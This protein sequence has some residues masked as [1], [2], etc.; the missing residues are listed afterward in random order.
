MSQVEGSRLVA[1]LGITL[2]GRGAQTWDHRAKTIGMVGFQNFSGGGGGE[3][4]DLPKNGKN[5]R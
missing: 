3:E 1:L 4:M 5:T 2:V